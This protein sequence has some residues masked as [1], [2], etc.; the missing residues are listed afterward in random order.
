MT[1]GFECAHLRWTLGTCIPEAPTL[2]T[3][4]QGEACLV[5]A[6]VRASSFGLQLPLVAAARVPSSPGQVVGVVKQS[7]PP[8]RSP[9]F[10]RGTADQ[11][12]TRSS[13]TEKKRSSSD[14]KEEEEEEKE[15]KWPRARDKEEG[16]RW[17]VADKIAEDVTSSRDCTIFAKIR[18]SVNRRNLLPI[19]TRFTKKLFPPPRVRIYQLEFTGEK[20]KINFSSGSCVLA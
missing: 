12:G 2:S 9:R 5:R 7:P 3:P 19:L 18:S 16:T 8:R 14:E 1:R 15:V 20:K 13:T 10:E 11:Q 4:R 17:R 6:C